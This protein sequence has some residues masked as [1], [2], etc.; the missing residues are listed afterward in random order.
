MNF[1]TRMASVTATGVWSGLV[2]LFMNYAAFVMVIAGALL[3]VAF[4]VDNIIVNLNS[5]W[6]LYYRY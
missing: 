4:I 5:I 3:A 1:F 2:G 6:Y